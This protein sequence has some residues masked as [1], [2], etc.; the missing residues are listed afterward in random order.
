MRKLSVLYR[1]VLNHYQTLF[2]NDANKSLLF[3]CN[4]I[5]DANK[6]GL[7][8]DE[9]LDSIQKHFVTQYPTSEIN[10]EFIVDITSTLISHRGI[11]NNAWWLL[12][13]DDTFK[14]GVAIRIKFLKKM[15]KITK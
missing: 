2:K 4:T 6:N 14:N 9:E 1:I 7:I 12:V 15:I 3:I 8:T 11:S 13:G 10:S 5:I